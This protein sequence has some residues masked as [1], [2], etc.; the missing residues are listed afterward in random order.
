MEYAVSHFN[1]FDV[2]DA[3]LQ[4]FFLLITLAP[5]SASNHAVTINVV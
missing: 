4:M 3:I 5:I 1:A 2:A